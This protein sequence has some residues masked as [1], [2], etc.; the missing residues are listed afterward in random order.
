MYVWTF[1]IAELFH[2]FQYIHPSINP[3]HSVNE[4]R[5]GVEAGEFHIRSILLFPELS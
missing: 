2:Y 3:A 4:A 1:R 5:S